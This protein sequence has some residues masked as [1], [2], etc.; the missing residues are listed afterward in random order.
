MQRRRSVMRAKLWKF[1]S[2][3]PKT[4]ASGV[5][6]SGS[7]FLRFVHLRLRLRR[8]GAD[9]AVRLRATHAGRGGRIW[10]LSSDFGAWRLCSP[11][12][13]SLL[14]SAV[15]PSRRRSSTAPRAF[16]SL[17]ARTQAQ[18]LRRW[19]RRTLTLPFGLPWLGAHFR[20]DAL[21][22]FFLVVVNL[23]GATT[24]LYAHR[25]RPARRDRHC[26]C[27]RSSGRFSPA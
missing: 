5:A 17:V 25:L 11:L 15:T 8:R 9:N 26:A 10:R 24:S 3:S 21:T 27:C 20:L 16:I 12:P 6:D 4:G 22:A 23:G 2:S 13:C 14:R 7:T 1:G 18:L 19:Q